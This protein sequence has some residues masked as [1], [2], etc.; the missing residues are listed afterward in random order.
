MAHYT[1]HGGLGSPYSMKMRAI[2]RYRRLPHIW[3]Q[4]DM[5]D[6]SM[7]AKV[8]APVIPIIE[9]PDGSWHNNSTP[10]IYTLE[11]LH[12]ERCDHSGRCGAGVPCLSAR[13][14]G[15]RMGHQ[16]DVPLSLVPRARPEADERMALLRPSARSGARCDPA[17]RR[18]VPRSPGRTHGAR[19]LHAGKRSDHR[20]VPP[21][22][23]WLCS[24]RM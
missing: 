11:K 24:R 16:G 1:I 8:K 19:R 7:F 9:F 2:F 6:R 3:K 22:R 20:G 10:M 18:D 15:G 4:V 14:H 5:A 21:G 13:R 17:K 23:S 12:S